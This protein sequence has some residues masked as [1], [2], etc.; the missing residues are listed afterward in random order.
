[1]SILSEGKTNPNLCKPHGFR[2]RRD[3]SANPK[4]GY[5]SY[6]HC[7]EIE[8]ETCYNLPVV[9]NEEIEV[10]L[11]FPEANRKCEKMT[12]TVPKITCEDEVM[13]YCFV[14]IFSFLCYF[15]YFENTVRLENVN[16]RIDF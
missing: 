9:K 8:Q 7:K 1:M 10:K 16:F 15:S 13:T 11:A 5:G 3:A 12:V 4:Y 14:Y 6:T 2:R